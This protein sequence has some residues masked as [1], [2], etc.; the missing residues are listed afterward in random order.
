MTC[1]QRIPR[2][3][4][5]PFRIITFSSTIFRAHHRG[6]LIYARSTKTNLLE[7]IHKTPKPLHRS[8]IMSSVYLSTVFMYL[9]ADMDQQTQ[10]LQQSSGTAFG[11]VN[12]KVLDISHTVSPTS[13]A[14]ISCKTILIPRSIRMT[15]LCPWLKPLMALNTT[16]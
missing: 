3:A 9:D 13:L 8:I 15:T 2:C 4:S 16:K 12:A 6:L 1:I 10:A 5:F 14:T 7:A 11:Q